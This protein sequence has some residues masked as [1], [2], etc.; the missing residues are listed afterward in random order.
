MKQTSI[1]PS[2]LNLQL[3]GHPRLGF[4]ALALI[5]VSVVLVLALG[6]DS[7]IV[8]VGHMD[9]MR[10]YNI[11]NNYNIRIIRHRMWRIMRTKQRL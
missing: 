3:L 5:V 10:Y 9:Q 11:G 1:A 6:Q 2:C 4:S 8:N 7:W